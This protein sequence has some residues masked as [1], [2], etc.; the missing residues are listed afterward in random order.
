M[1]GLVGVHKKPQEAV[2]FE[3]TRMLMEDQDSPMRRPNPLKPTEM[4]PVIRATNTN[5]K[6]QPLAIQVVQKII[7]NEFPGNDPFAVYNQVVRFWEPIKAAF[8]K[9]AKLYNQAYFTAL[10]RMRDTL[11]P[12]NVQILATRLEDSLEP[13]KPEGVTGTEGAITQIRANIRTVLGL[14]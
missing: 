9:D 2:A 7:M 6:L 8:G 3:V 1:K 11:T 4:I 12:E 14:D 10:F 13:L 5:T